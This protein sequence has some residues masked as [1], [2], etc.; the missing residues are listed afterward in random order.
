MTTLLLERPGVLA[1]APDAA[2]PDPAAGE[3]LVRVRAVGVCGTDFHAWR[4]KQPFFTYPRILGHEV[5]VEVVA[6]GKDVTNVR[7]G[8]RCAVEPYVDCGQCIACR[9]GRGNCCEKLR[10]LGVH[11][12]G[13]MRDHYVVPARKLHPSRTLNCEQLALVET[14]GIGAH[15][16]A[17]A[18]VSA[19]DAVLVVG[20]GPI[21]LA[22]LQFVRAAGARAVAMDANAERLA[23]A[24]RFGVEETL[25]PGAELAETESALRARFGGDLPNV[26]IDATGNQASMRAAFRLVAH[27]GRLTFIGL[28]QGEIAFDDPD[29]HK[30]EL[31]V[32]AS[33]N[34]LAAD[35]RTII[36]L[37]E[38]GAVDTL[39]WITHRAKAAEAAERFV[40]WLQPEAKCLK[41]LISF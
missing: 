11:A 29:F 40:E 21:G 24:R 30:R 6:V 12:D 10:V 35:F 36:G 26:V 17:R 37:V 25:P 28:V 41:G 39:P 7:P 31:T 34:S 32:L 16:V 15:G 14:L 9:A 19:K 5:G 22:A 2:P 8:D 23:L 20:A 3:A 18:Q 4:G 38:S 1:Y 13:G 33:R 27:G